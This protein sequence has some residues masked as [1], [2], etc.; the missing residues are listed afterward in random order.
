MDAVGALG[1]GG[2][3]DQPADEVRP[4]QGDLLGDEAADG[5]PED[6]DPTNF[7]KFFRARVGLA[8][9]A[10]AAKSRVPANR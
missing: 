10:F 6:V 9:G 8:P 1:G 2:R 4:D 5:E 3:E 7:S